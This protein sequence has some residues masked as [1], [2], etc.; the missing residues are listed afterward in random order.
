MRFR[1][2]TESLDGEP[3]FKKPKGVRTPAYTKDGRKIVLTKGYM[4]VE[5]HVDG[6]EAGHMEIGCLM[7]HGQYE[8]AF[9]VRR[10]H[11]SHEF[12]RQGIATAMYDFAFRAGF[13]PLK[14]SQTLTDGGKAVWA[15]HL[16]DKAKRGM[17]QEYH[18]DYPNRFHW[19][20]LPR[21]GE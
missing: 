12:Q 21:D 2:I 18:T 16:N 19:R 10:I 6:Q 20:P 4:G 15:K 8:N 9:Y 3:P 5:A 1:E 17:S 14:M 11:V 13:R 7:N